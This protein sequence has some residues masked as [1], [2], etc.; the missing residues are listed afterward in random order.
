MVD[1]I[2]RTLARLYVTRR[3]L[4]EW[5]TAAQAKASRDLDLARL[6]PPDGR[7]RG[8]RGRP[9][10][11]LVLA[12][13]AGRGAGS[14]RRSWSLWLLAP[15]VARWVSLPPPEP[16]AEQL[17]ADDVETLRLTA[18]RT[19]RFFETFVGPEDNGLPPDN[20]QDDPD[21]GRRPSHLADEHR[22]VPAGDRDRPRLRVDRHARDGGAPRGD[23]RHRSTASSGSAGT[24]T[25]GTT[26]ATCTGST[27]VRVVGRQ[28]QP[29]RPPADARQ[30]LPPDDRPAASGRG[31]AGRDRRRDHADARG[32]R[33]RSA[34][35]G[36]ARR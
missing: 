7:R 14:P 25:T 5:T 20:F 33:R 32:G 36:G 28:R 10:W 15:L 19:W 24:S 6:L 2:V 11:S 30:R 13:E 17:S 12:R 23:A 34:T 1:A 3:N 8:A 16:A 35:T 9:R 18:R 21:A 26:R 22:D 27:R 29:R 31:R 4:L